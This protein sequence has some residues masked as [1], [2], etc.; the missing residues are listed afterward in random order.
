MIDHPFPGAPLVERPVRTAVPLDFSAP[1]NDYCEV[2][3]FSFGVHSST[4]AGGVPTRAQRNDMSFT[5]PRDAFGGKL[6]D[7]VPV[8]LVVTAFASTFPSGR[9]AVTRV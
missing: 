4:A 9:T 6:D 1:L 8:L 3:S 7:H 2:Y 5:K